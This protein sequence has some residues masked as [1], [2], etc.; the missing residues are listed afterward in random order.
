MNKNFFI[1][2]NILIKSQEQQQLHGSYF[3][4]YYI[5]FKLFIAHSDILYFGEIMLF[6]PIQLHTKERLCR[7][8]SINSS[9]YDY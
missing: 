2:N 5:I 9:M 6:I 8:P 1:I 7:L 4:F 3:L